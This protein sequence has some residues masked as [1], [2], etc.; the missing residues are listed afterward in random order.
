MLRLL[1]DIVVSVVVLLA[2]VA[3]GIAGL[4]ALPILLVISLCLA[5]FFTVHVSRVLREE[6][7]ERE[8][9]SD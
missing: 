5:V 7:A 2:L 4:V 3:M 8:A 9:N 6:E 1:W